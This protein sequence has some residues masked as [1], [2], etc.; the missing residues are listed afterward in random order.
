MLLLV[1]GIVLYRKIINKRIRE[2]GNTV[3]INDPYPTRTSFDNPVYNGQYVEQTSELYR[4]VDTDHTDTQYGDVDVN[5]GNNNN[6]LE[7]INNDILPDE[8]EV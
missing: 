5:Y 4:E 3:N 2:N 1:S 6:N 7:H 8:E